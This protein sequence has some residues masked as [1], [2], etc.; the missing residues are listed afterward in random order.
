MKFIKIIGISLVLITVYTACKKSKS[1]T[2][3]KADLLTQKPWKFAAARSKQDNG[4]WEDIFLNIDSCRR[5]DILS[6]STSSF[7]AIDG[8]LI[9]CFPADSQIVASGSWAFD[10]NET[11]IVLTGNQI[12][13][14]LILTEDTLKY[15]ETGPSG[16]STYTAEYTY[17][18]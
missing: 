17:I 6:F 4:N 18:H 1:D 2:K 11:Q 10:N 12:K 9:K 13:S 7:Y 8:G 3:S 16:W 14:L 15:S 5:D